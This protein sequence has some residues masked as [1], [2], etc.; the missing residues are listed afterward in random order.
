V[1][2]GSTRGQLIGG[3]INDTFTIALTGG[4]IGTG[5]TLFSDASPIE[6]TI[7]L[8]AQLGTYSDYVNYAASANQ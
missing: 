4:T 5:I 1:Y 2:T 7:A 8:G 3:L 6:K